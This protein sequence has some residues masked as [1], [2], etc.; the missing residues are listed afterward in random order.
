M[1][2]TEDWSEHQA[3]STNITSMLS[4]VDEN[5]GVV[6]TVNKISLFDSYFDV[7]YVNSG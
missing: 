2:S 1:L 6:S 3:L 7:N 4:F 5:Q